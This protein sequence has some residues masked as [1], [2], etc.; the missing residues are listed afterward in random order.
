MYICWVIFDAM[1]SK[2]KCEI[3]CIFMLK[4]ALT[5]VNCL[6]SGIFNIR[7]IEFQK[8]NLY[9]VIFKYLGI[10]T[11]IIEREKLTA[12]APIGWTPE[13]C[14]KI[15]ENDRNDRNFGDDRNCRNRPKFW[16]YF[17][18]RNFRN[19]AKFRWFRNFGTNPNNNQMRFRKNRDDWNNTIELFLIEF[20][21][22]LSI[23]LVY[24]MKKDMP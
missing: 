3:L 4:N 23:R 22:E 15:Q 10:Q 16:K 2:S 11:T 14:A 7:C 12:R 17:C 19:Y 9:D 18:S 24:L 13:N 20:V 21:H 8:K 5:P 6:I 1:A